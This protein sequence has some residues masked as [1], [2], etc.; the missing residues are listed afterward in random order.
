MLTRI[1]VR[2]NPLVYVS[3]FARFEDFSVP[4]FPVSPPEVLFPTLLIIEK[5]IS[6]PVRLGGDFYKKIKNEA[7]FISSGGKYSFEVKLPDG[8]YQLYVIFNQKRDNKPEGYHYYGESNKIQINL[9]ADARKGF[10]PTIIK[11]IPKE[12]NKIELSGIFFPLMDKDSDGNEYRVTEFQTI[13]QA[14]PV[15]TNYLMTGVTFTIGTNVGYNCSEK[16]IAARGIPLDFYIGN[17]YEFNF[18]EMNGSSP[19]PLDPGT[20]HIS[21]DMRNLDYFIIDGKVLRIIDIVNP[22]SIYWYYKESST[23]GSEEYLSY[24]LITHYK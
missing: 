9:I 22:R 1:P 12:I 8:D 16:F 20:G 23:F 21:I 5:K 6:R 17:K 7:G 24:F 15:E 3:G 4:A 19:N 14:I 2:N 10:D 13:G 11:K 18:T